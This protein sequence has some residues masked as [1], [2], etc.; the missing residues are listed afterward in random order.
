MNNGKIIEHQLIGMSR[1]DGLDF[2]SY[3][4]D[5]RALWDNLPDSLKAQV[6]DEV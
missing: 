1:L 2:A 4:I 3:S 5:N 6:I